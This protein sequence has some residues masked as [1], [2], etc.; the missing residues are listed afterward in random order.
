MPTEYEVRLCLASQHFFPTPGGAQLRF[1]RYLPGLRARGVRTVVVAGTPKLRKVAASP[2]TEEWY[3][4]PGGEVLAPESI[5]GIEIHRIRLPERKSRRRSMI[6]HRRLLDF[7]RQP[8]YRSD[9]VQLL[10]SLHP[11]STLWLFRLRSLG[12]PLVYGYTLPV[13][14]PA[15]SLKRTFRRLTLRILYRQLDCIVASSSTTKDLLLDFGVSTRID[16]IPNGVDLQRFRPA[17][18]ARERRA[19]RTALGVPDEHQIITTVGALIP[20]KGSDL[21]LE[22]WIDLAARFPKA[23]VFIVGPRL[24]GDTSIL[25]DF[26]RR[27]ETLVAQSGA[28]QRVH[29]TG[30]VNNVEEYLRASDLFVFP[31]LSEGMGNV[32]LEAM[33]SGIPVILTPFVGLPEDFGT[34]GQEYLLVERNP[35][36]LTEVMARLLK[37]DTL[38][39]TLGQRARR[40]VE[41]T[42]DVERSLDRYAGLYR[43]LAGQARRRRAG[44]H[45]QTG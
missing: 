40:W 30:L 20:R 34:A 17:T 33:A 16:V 7:C 3:R 8:G 24:A 19:L 45:R 37:S 2:G 41:G 27:I 44:G 14:L 31:S 18:D 26:Q 11:V 35:A 6:F 21:L 32:V 13:D 23:E 1:L 22:A 5:D 4:H 25:Q 10:P 9:V 42:M 15:N 39:L 29:F 36:A 38:R 12:I 28:A 43:E